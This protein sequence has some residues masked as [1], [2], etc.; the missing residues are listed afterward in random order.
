MKRN[1]VEAL[2]ARIRKD[3]PGG[4]HEWT[5]A[6]DTCG[7]GSV[8]FSGRLRSVHIVTYEA[9][10]GPVPPGLELDHLCRN[11]AC[12]NPDHLEPVTHRENQLRG[13]GFVAV[14]AAKTHCDR[15][16]L[17]DGPNT[18]HRPAGRRGCRACMYAAQRRYEARKR[19]RALEQ[20]AEHRRVL[21]GLEAELR[22]QIA[23]PAERAA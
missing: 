20:V 17:F 22:K 4:C 11:R 8:K 12:C 6:R 18:I 13:V 2:N 16:H 10:K 14:N 5:G 3:A 23:A 1:T 19:K 21:D 7:Y 9:S 15:G